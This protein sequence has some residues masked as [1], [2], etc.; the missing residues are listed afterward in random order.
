MT[1]AVDG[2]LTP[3]R[4]AALDAHL[5][6]CDGCRRE[7]AATERLLSVLETLPTEAVVGEGLEQATLRR[8]RQVAAEDEESAPGRWWT[9]WFPLPVLAAAAAVAVVALGV[10]T[11]APESGRGVLTGARK[12]RVARVDRP[13]PRSDTPRAI[14]PLEGPPPELAAAPD[15]FMNLPILRNMEKLEHFEAI[16]TTTLD[17]EPAT[18]DGEP[19]PSNG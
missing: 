18:P 8:V 16:Q 14:V 10:M 9:R 12:T 2:E 7:L 3:R 4:R 11:Y 5:A 15:K 13:A 1:A 17:D 6:R 19:E